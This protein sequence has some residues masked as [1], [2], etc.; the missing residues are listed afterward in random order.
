[1]KYVT[2]WQF[3]GYLS[4]EYF[5]EYKCSEK[6]K[7]SQ[8]RSC[9]YPLIS[10]VL[11]GQVPRLNQRPIWFPIQKTLKGVLKTVKSWVVE[12]HFFETFIKG[13]KVYFLLKYCIR[14]LSLGVA[15]LNLFWILEYVTSKLFVGTLSA[16]CPDIKKVSWCV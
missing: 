8:R 12:Y 13:Y 3:Q 15:L 11:W 6:S 16:D 9:L 2:F 10:V 4:F 7:Y 14:N 5:S 1:M